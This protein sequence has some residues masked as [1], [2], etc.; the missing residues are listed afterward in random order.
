MTI[1]N[2]DGLTMHARISQSDIVKWLVLLGLLGCLIVTTQPI[3]AQEIASS[4]K[5]RDVSPDQKF[6]MQILYDAEMNQQL[7]EGEKA[8]SPALK[9]VLKTF[10]YLEPKSV[11]ERH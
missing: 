4:K 2:G 1:L 8:D 11:Q 5:I 9:E 7:I 6:A 10:V 3:C